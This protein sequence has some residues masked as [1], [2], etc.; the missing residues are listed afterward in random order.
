MGD[1]EKKKAAA[2]FGSAGMAAA[3]MIR[4][5]RG[6]RG[7]TTPPPVVPVEAETL[8]TEPVPDPEDLAL[9]DPDDL[10]LPEPEPPR[11][12]R[13]AVVEGPKVLRAV[14][15]GHTGAGNFGHG[16]DQVFLRLDGVRLVAIT[17]EN[18]EAL[19]ETRVRSQAERAYSDY[20]EMLEKEQP[21]LVS[22][23]PRWTGER[24]DMVKAALEAGAHVLCERPLARTLREADELVALA[25][26]KNLK[27]A[28]LHQMRC[29]P[30]LRAFH[31]HREEIIGDLLEMRV[32]G[33]MDHR[34]GG[35]DLLVLGTHLFDLVRWF[36][37]DPTFCTASIT[38][39]GESVIAEDAHF[40]EKEDLGPVL[41]DSIHAEF[42]MDSGVHVTY[43]SDRRLHLIH[44]PW[45]IEFLGTK[46][47]VRLFA[48]M[49]P[50]LSMLVEDDPAS[51]DRLA[52]WLRLPAKEEPYHEPVDKLTGT[53]A[54]NRLVVL[55]WLSAISTDREPKC[56]GE[57]ALKSLEMIHAVWQ[58]GATM[59]R[60]YF[61]LANRFHPLDGEHA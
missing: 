1:D 60:A 29:D 47:R 34:A 44:G 32:F 58:A 55:D 53:D 51:P 35:E 17:D 10:A 14:A 7:E 3:G 33:M 61:P 19:E 48:G 40:S 23:A 16:L 57:S 12:R 5:S 27:L 26:E 30:H 31:E 4:I 21:D 59:K 8:P 25:A 45:G 11:P 42:V 41:G 20:R 56:S 43:V 22:V 50:T 2:M 36:A 38:K 9:P 39:G 49:P 6:K 28:V 18:A 15:I 37:G 13:V 46:G 24:Y 54:A 52:R